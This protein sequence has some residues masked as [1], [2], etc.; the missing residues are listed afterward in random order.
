MK[1]LKKK[2]VRYQLGYQTIAKSADINYP[3]IRSNFQTSQA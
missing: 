2:K 3:V 1:D